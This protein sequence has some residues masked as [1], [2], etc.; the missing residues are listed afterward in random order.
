MAIK[1][2]SKSSVLNQNKISFARSESEISCELLLIGGGGAGKSGGGGAGGVLYYGTETPNTTGVKIANGSSIIFKNG[3]YTISIG[4]GGTG[5]TLTPG[6]DSNINGP[7]IS[8]TAFGGGASQNT[9]VSGP[10]SYQT[11]GSGGGGGRSSTATPQFGGQGY[12]GQGYNGGTCTQKTFPYP[13]AGGG[14]AG[15]VGAANSGSTPGS[16]GVG[17]GY[18]ISGSLTYYA[19]GGGGGGGDDGS[20]GGASIGYATTAGGT[21]SGSGQSGSANTGSG[22]GGQGAGGSNGGSGGSGVLIIAYL[23]TYPPIS[24]ING[25]TYDQPTRSGYRVYRFTSGTGTI[26]F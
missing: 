18:T 11:G 1:R 20:A 7:G 21:S 25:L 16:G 9:D 3:T 12:A 26:T 23:N 5:G 22:G 8:L 24:S 13:G 19:G 15:S 6:T 14:G 2:I 10:F 4:S 17:V